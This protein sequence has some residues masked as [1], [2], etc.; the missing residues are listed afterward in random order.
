MKLLIG[1]GLAVLTLSACTKSIPFEEKLKYEVYEKPDTNGEYLMSASMLNASRSSQDALPFSAGDNKRVKLEWSKE[2]LRIVEMEADSRF[3]GN[4]TNNKLVL[5]IP[6]EYVDYQCAKDKYGDC[7]NSEEV[8]D[9]IP[10]DKKTKFKFKPEAAKSSR[11]ETL[12]ILLEQELTGGLCY[13]ETSSRVVDLKLEKDAL[14]MAVERTFKVN[15]ACLSTM[16]KLSDTTVSAVFHYSLVKTSSV[17]T[18]GFKTVNYPKLDENTFGFFTT[19]SQDL[20]SDNNA[21]TGGKKV[22]MNH[23]NPERSSIEYFLSEEFSKPEHAKIR[24]LTYKVVN[25]LNDGLSKAGAKFHINLHD[26]SGQKVG[27]IRNSMIVLVEDPV[28]SSVIGYGPQ[29]EDP[30]TGEIISARTVMFLGTIKKYIKSTY[31]DILRDKAEIKA[32]REAAAKAQTDPV[33]GTPSKEEEKGDTGGLIIE[34][35]LQARLA[36]SK[37]KSQSPK[38][39]V[40]KSEKALKTAKLAKVKGTAG[41]SSSL[42][43][44]QIKQMVAE[45][46]TYTKQKNSDYAGGIQARLKY[47]QEAKNCAFGMAPGVMSFGINPDLADKFADDAKPWDKL[48]DSEKQ[49]VIDLILPEVWVPTLIHEMGHNLGLRHNFQGSEDPENFYTETELEGFQIN[50]KIPFSTVMEYGDDLKALPVLGKYDIAALK[51]A[52]AQKVEVVDTVWAEQNQQG[53]EV[54]QKTYKSVPLKGTLQETVDAAYASL[55]ADQKS[56][57]D[58]E[59]IDVLKPYGY[60]TDE[61]TGINAGCRRFDL[62]TSYTEIVQNEINTYLNNYELAYKRN[63]RASMSLTDEPMYAAS[64]RSRFM[65]LRLMQEIY[66][67]MQQIYPVHLADG[68]PNWENIPSF[69]DIKD[70]SDLVGQ[71]LMSVATT[72]D[73]TC[74]LSAK[75]DAKDASGKALKLNE[76][77]IAGVELLDKLSTRGLISCATVTE[78][79]LE[80]IGLQDYEVIGQYGKLFQSRK[81]PESDNAYADQIDVR[82]YWIDKLVATRML[83]GRNM[84]ISTLD[85]ATNNYADRAEFRAPLA[86]MT[87]AQLLNR[88]SGD[89]DI[90]FFDGTKKTEPLPT[91]TDLK[92]QKPLFGDLATALG[93]PNDNV[94]FSQVYVDAVSSRMVDTAHK[95]SGNE[96]LDLIRVSRTGISESFP[97]SFKSLE[98]SN[99]RYGADPKKNLVATELITVHETAK[100]LEAVELQSDKGRNRLIMIYQLKAQKKPAPADLT[101]VEKVAWDLEAD[102]ILEYLQGVMPNPDSLKA[103]LSILPN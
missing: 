51:F 93:I 31:A 35:S 43:A 57:V 42:S 67:R 47:L 81:D 59:R 6:V 24:E 50:H 94:S 61:H 38:A 75:E 44:A 10:W 86:D 23:W 74:V 34:K 37:F 52:Y 49:H 26:N 55:P 85:R 21:T 60:C 20:D 72:P 29:T 66:E 78:G 36:K 84:G 92:V 7:T 95:V 11:L 3:S 12:P 22:I 39:L 25:S 33:K 53:E 71:F 98:I 63:G 83:F 91:V 80:L 19:E 96:F 28:A 56:L 18:P 14:N 5:E 30:L 15:L 17:L 48:S 13:S 87:Q 70:A 40:A 103:T 79:D 4:G 100:K 73:L 54:V 9:D 69:K 64:V 77:P 32:I 88:M 8:R 89:Q 27:D 58:S 65:S 82:G 62:G 97:S 41:V 45:V 1:S 90:E 76:R 16:D 2:S 101:E 68:N 99:L 102:Q 46:K